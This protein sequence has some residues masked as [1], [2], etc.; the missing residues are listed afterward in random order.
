MF[1]KN[2]FRTNYSSFFFRKIRILPFVSIIYMIRI[3]LFG[4]QESIQRHFSDAQYVRLPKKSERSI[5]QGQHGRSSFAWVCQRC[6][7]HWCNAGVCRENTFTYK[8]CWCK[9]PER[10]GT[11]TSC[12]SR[13]WRRKRKSRCRSSDV[14]LLFDSGAASQA[15]PVFFV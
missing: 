13:C 4:L 7:T 6:W 3:R 14:E 1:R 2:P 9:A 5:C 11:M 10:H 15:I 8:G 12:G